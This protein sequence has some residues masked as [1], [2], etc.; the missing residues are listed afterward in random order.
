[1]QLVHP[2]RGIPGGQGEVLQGILNGLRLI[3]IHCWGGEV[4]P[5]Q[6]INKRQWQVLQMGVP[7]RNVIVVTQ[8]KISQLAKEVAAVS[9]MPFTSHL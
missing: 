4:P 6:P 1:M 5:P 8:K 3:E 2:A 7:H 9:L